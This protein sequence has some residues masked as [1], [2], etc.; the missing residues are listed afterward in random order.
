MS[1][2]LSN[3]VFAKLR[4]QLFSVRMYLA[5]PVLALC[6]VGSVWGLTD[7]N[8]VLPAEIPLDS[9]MD[10]LFVSS[11]FV[12]LSATLVGVIISYDGVS[13]DRASGVLEVKLSQPCPRRTQAISMLLG[14]WLSIGIPV[15]I[16]TI[17]SYGVIA[18]RMQTNPGLMDLITHLIAT[19]L[20]ILWY[21]QFSLLASS[22][23]KNQSSSISIGIGMWFTFTMLWLLVTS[24]LAGLSGIEVGGTDAWVKFEAIM[25]LFSPN[26]VYHHL[27]E[28]RMPQ[29]NRGINPILPYIA[30]IIWTLVPMFAFFERFER[31]TP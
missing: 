24:V 3:L 25:D 13:K 7:P 9:P 21:V 10:V 11:L 19:E 27:L 12:L 17:V 1:S 29:I 26:G 31:L 30:A 8:T 15:A 22:Y 4:E 5:I 16:L 23:A 6:I 14:Y 20:V 18:Y 28:S 2:P